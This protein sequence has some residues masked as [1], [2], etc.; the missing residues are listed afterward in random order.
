M[1]AR[2]FKTGQTVTL[3]QNRARATPKGRFEIVRPLPTEHGNHQ[4]RIKSVLDGHERVVQES[5]LD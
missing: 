4:Y 2:K 1:T 3:T 5:E